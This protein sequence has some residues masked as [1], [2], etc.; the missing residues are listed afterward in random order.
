MN[1]FSQQQVDNEI[2]IESKLQDDF[3][4][5]LEKDYFEMETEE[6]NGAM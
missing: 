3:E 6:R 1:R 4:K 2:D 5:S